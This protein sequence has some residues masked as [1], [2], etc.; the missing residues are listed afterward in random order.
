DP[1]VRW[2]IITE[3]DGV[4]RAALSG[5]DVLRALLPSYLL[6]DRNLGRVYDREGAREVVVGALGRTLGE[7]LDSMDPDEWE[8]PH[9]AEHPT[10]LE[11]AGEFIRTG[12]TVAYIKGSGPENARFTTLPGLFARIIEVVE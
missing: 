6:G 1:A 9:V 5:S 12:S 3:D 4:P 2:L 10:A 8:L 11:I 7:V